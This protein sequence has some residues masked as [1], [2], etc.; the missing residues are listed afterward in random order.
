MSSLILIIEDEPPQAEMLRYNLEKAGFQTVVAPSG[1][2]AFVQLNYEI[3]D[4]MIVDWMLPEL[5][6]IDICRRLRAQAAFKHI[7]IIM[8][9][10]R[11][12][13]GDQVLGLEAGADD[14]VIKPFSPKEMVARVRALLRRSGIA[15]AGETIEYKGIVI[16]LDAHKVTRDGEL[17]HLS[18]KGYGLLHALMKRPGHVFSRKTLLRHVW[19]SDV[20]V[21]EQ[22]VDVHI[23]RLRK[24]LNAN[25]KPDIIRT[26]RGVGYAIDFK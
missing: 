19:G 22:T 1:E 4:L 3:P 24:A 26:V 25:G 13:E 2:E 8:L 15:A 14:Y 11:G 16:D 10:A 23:G 5:S 9:T 12:E 20:F 17:I 21:E 18:L 6:G 7:P